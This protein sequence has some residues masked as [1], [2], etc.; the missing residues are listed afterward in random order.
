[1]IFIN[2]FLQELKHINN[3]CVN[4][5]LIFPIL[6][7]TELINHKNH[8][9]TA[10]S[11]SI[12]DYVD[13]FEIKKI[14]LDFIDII[15]KFS[16]KDSTS[17]KDSA[18]FLREINE[19]DLNDKNLKE[20]NLK[21]KELKEN[22]LKEKNLK[23]KKNNYI[24]NNF[25]A[26]ELVSFLSS[27]FAFGS[28]VSIL[29]FLIDLYKFIS[30]FDIIEKDLSGLIFQNQKDIPYYRWINKKIVFLLIIS[31][32]AF[33]QKYF[34]IFNYCI[35][36]LKKNQKTTY[37]ESMIF[38]SNR[39]F[40]IIEDIS[41]KKELPLNKKE[42]IIIKNFLPQSLSSTS[43]KRY[44]LFLKWVI[45]KNFPDLGLWSFKEPL[46]FDQKNLFF[47]L[48]I[49]I[50]EISSILFNY[51]LEATY[52]YFF[53]KNQKEY[54]KDY[55]ENSFL[56]FEKQMLKYLKDYKTAKDKKYSKDTNLE[57]ELKEDLKF[58]IK[59]DFETI[60]FSKIVA[61]I[62]LRYLDKNKNSKIKNLLKKFFNEI[63]K[64][65][66][67]A[68]I[69]QKLEKENEKK[70]LVKFYRYLKSYEKFFESS[71]DR[72]SIFLNKKEHLKVVTDF[73][74]IF[75]EEDPL[76]FD[77]PISIIRSPILRKKGNTSRKK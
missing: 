60:D 15:K 38:F 20:K 50:L 24:D 28:R 22:N 76:V 43:A 34:S 63:I 7:Y 40:E 13:N 27:I 25:R 14:A 31:L 10:F 36:I 5:P 18:K 17:K 70:V 72:N 52:F 12:C 49:H 3:N 57:I 68:E 19:K 62:N 53:E 30:P 9:D 75:D 44:N 29:K 54:Y 32:N 47:P 11:G 69:F 51:L 8:Y 58:D 33:Y 74:I 42:K 67:S 41:N 64:S 45:R 23:D 26:I 6:T 37:L 77:L 55:F 39:L 61:L 66:Y 16:E 65:E 59:K 2:S 71:F 35:N 21:E 1:M 4:D 73:Y 56:V 46:L 48:D